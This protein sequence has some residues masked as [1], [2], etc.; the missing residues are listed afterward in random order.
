MK[1]QF[2]PGMKRWLKLLA[3]MK[4]LRGTAFDVFGRTAERKMERALIVQF[5]QDMGEV[6][7]GLSQQS[8]PTAIAAKVRTRGDG[9]SLMERI[10]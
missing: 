7:N 2:G 6:L 1:R 9:S 10:V 3:K 8:L 4:G 5:E